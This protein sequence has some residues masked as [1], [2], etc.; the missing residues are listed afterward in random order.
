MYPENDLSAGIASDGVASPAVD[1]HKSS[2]TYRTAF[3]VH[4]RPASEA[5]LSAV[6]TATGKDQL[7]LTPLY[8][9][10]DPDALD[11]LFDVPAYSRPKQH[12]TITFEYEDC[13]V[14][15]KAHGI[16]IVEPGCEDGRVE[17]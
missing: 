1:F 2:N 14:S 13:R 3:D 11:A 9:V 12:L 6:A 7:E 17:R 8:S 15:A 5:I 10:I 4:T 16:V